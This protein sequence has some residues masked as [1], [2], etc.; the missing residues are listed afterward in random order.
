[1]DFERVLL[2]KLAARFGFVAHHNSQPE[3]RD[4]NF[5]DPGQE[6]C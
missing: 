3:N 6:L 4:N 5:V 2:D 1:M